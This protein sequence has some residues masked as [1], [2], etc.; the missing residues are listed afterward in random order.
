MTKHNDFIAQAATML[1]ELAAIWAQKARDYHRRNNFYY[2]TDYSWGRFK[3]FLRGHLSDAGYPHG[4]R[5]LDKALDKWLES[6]TTKEDFKR[7]AG[8]F[9]PCYDPDFDP[10]WYMFA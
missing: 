3:C 2:G 1:P 10:N 9:F 8:G 4:D 5:S 7:A 6:P